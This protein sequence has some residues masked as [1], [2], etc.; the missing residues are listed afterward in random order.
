MDEDIDDRFLPK[1][2]NLFVNSV[3]KIERSLLIDHF[4]RIDVF[5]PNDSL[6]I[7]RSHPF[8]FYSKN[9]LQNWKI[10]RKIWSARKFHSRK[11]TFRDALQIILARV[12]H[13]ILLKMWQSN[14]NTDFWRRKTNA[15]IPKER[16]SF[17][18]FCPFTNWCLTTIRT[19]TQLSFG[20][21]YSTRGR[22]Q[23][24][25]CK[26]LPQFWRTL[27]KFSE[28]MVGIPLRYPLASPH[29]NGW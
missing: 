5:S 25:N 14:N 20:E 27:F 22:T 15:G 21:N 23:T 17:A 9:L 8:R 4:A 18:T 16:F 13:S 6:V 3:P 11:L 19:R 2:K 29:S 7:Q 28:N 12:I 1:R 10:F 26:Y 24:W